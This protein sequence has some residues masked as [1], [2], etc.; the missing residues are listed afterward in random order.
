[1]L[2]IC[3]KLDQKE[4]NQRKKQ[5]NVSFLTRTNFKGNNVVG[6][7]SFQGLWTWKCSSGASEVNRLQ[8]WFLK[9]V[10]P[11][12]KHTKLDGGKKEN[13]LQINFQDAPQFFL[14]HQSHNDSGGQPSAKL[15]ETT[16]QMMQE[17][18]HLPLLSPLLRQLCCRGCFS[19][20]LV[21][22]FFFNP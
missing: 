9:L 13:I 1:M 21:R 16:R 2:T 12:S 6:L 10:F 15:K 8:A 22:F 17:L 20:L 3:I 5:K 14:P 7:A 4:T 11:T 19:G 18:H